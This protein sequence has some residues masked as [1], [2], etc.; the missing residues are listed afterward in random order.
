MKHSEKLKQEAIES[1]SDLAYMGKK[2]ICNLIVLFC[3]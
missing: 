1:D 2:H 3:V